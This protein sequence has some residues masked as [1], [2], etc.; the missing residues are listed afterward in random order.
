MKFSLKSAPLVLVVM[1]VAALGHLIDAPLAAARTPSIAPAA[2]SQVDMEMRSTVGILLDEIPTGAPRRQAAETARQHDDA[3]WI[4]KAQR[5]IRLT[6]YRL[7][8]RSGYYDR[9]K[10]PL[11]LPDR[12]VWN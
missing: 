9:P 6:D 1:F 8:F 2:G 12:A 11:P 3:F 5:Q 4:A 7:V 10:G